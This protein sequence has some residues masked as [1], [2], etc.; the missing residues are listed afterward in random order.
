MFKIGFKNNYKVLN[1][2]TEIGKHNVGGVG[3]FMDELYKYHSEDTGFVYIYD[4]NDT[5]TI[6]TDDYPDTKD[7]LAVS[8]G[9][10][11]EV[12]YLSYDIAVI[13]FYVLSCL[14]SEDYIRGRK[15][16]YVVHSV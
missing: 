3:T 16:V 1:F 15:L 9:E 12:M 7:I 4:G 11:D 13:H 8:S 2:T 10:I 5:Q 6:S 14:V